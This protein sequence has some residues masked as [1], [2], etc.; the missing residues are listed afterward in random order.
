MTYCTVANLLARTPHTELMNRERP[1]TSVVSRLITAIQD[2][3]VM[4]IKIMTGALSNQRLSVSFDCVTIVGEL[5]E[6]RTII[7]L[8]RLPR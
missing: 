3:L 1:T 2:D 8:V 4:V 5:D 6:P 7:D